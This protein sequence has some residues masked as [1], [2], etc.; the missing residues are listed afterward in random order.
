MEVVWEHVLAHLFR[1]VPGTRWDGQVPT[2]RLFNR[3]RQ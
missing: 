2:V 1:F 3:W